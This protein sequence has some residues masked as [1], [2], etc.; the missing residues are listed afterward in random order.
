MRPID[1]DEFTKQIAAMA[2]TNNYPTEKANAWCALIDAQPTIYDVNE[3]SSM[4]DELKQYRL[5]GTVEEC[6]TAMM[7]WKEQQ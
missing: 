1:A 7:R 3:I 4:I 6:R 5:I 2:I